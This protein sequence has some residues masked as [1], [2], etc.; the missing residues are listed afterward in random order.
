VENIPIE[1]LTR[2]E[3]VLGYIENHPEVDIVISDIMMPEMNGWELLTRIK[4]RHPL[5]TVI[6]FSGNPV[7]LTS[8]PD[9]TPAPDHLFSKPVP[10]KT[11]METIN[12]SGR[13]KL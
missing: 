1:T 13:Q 4:H 9:H 5:M 6:L 2:S 11:L 7:Q 10:L 3:E 12:T 8:K